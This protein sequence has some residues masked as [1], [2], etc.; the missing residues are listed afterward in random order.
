MS[1]SNMI[2]MGAFWLSESKSGEKYFSGYLNGAKLMIF[3]NKHKT[4]DKHPDYIMYL[5]P[6]PKENDGAAKQEPVQD[7]ILF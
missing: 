2:K 5:A 3:K 7:A 1:D 4:E 6:N